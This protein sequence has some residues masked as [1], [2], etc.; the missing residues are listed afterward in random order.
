[1]KKCFNVVTR[2]LLF[3][4]IV[5]SMSHAQ[6]ISSPHLETRGAATQLIVDGRPFVMLSGELDNSSS[7]SLEYMKSVWP[8]LAA[9]GLN[10]V[11]TPLSWELIE[12]T[13][14]NFDFTVVDGL[15]NQARHANERIVFLWFGSWKNGMSSYAPVWVKADTQRFHRVIEYGHEVEILSTFGVATEQADARA[16][17]ALMRHIKQVDGDRHTVLMMQLENE[18]G[19]L[20]DS[21]DH[22]ESANKA[23]ESPVPEQLTSYLK[24]HYNKLYPD[25]R[26]RWDAHGDKAEGTWAEVFGDN[27]RGDEIFM[28]WNYARYI[29]AVA[30]AGKAEYNIPMYVNTWLDDGTDPPGSYPCGDPEPWVI[31]IWRAAGSSIDIY[32]PDLY[33][34]DF[35][36]W[37]QRYHRDGNP[38]Y[39][40]EA[41]GGTTGAA[42]VFYALGQEAGIGFSPYAIDDWSTDNTPLGKSY[43]AIAEVMPLLLED[44]AKGDDRGF[45]LGPD[46]VINGPKADFTM[47]GYTL[48]VTLD[49]GFGDHAKSG[50]GMIMSL[51]KDEFLGVGKGFCVSFTPRPESGL[52]VGIAAVDEGTFKEGKWVPGRRLNGDEDYQGKYWRFDSQGVRIEKVSLYRFQ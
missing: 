24:A 10:T 48:H 17:A 7:S 44:Q 21:R 42:N 39:M 6:E 1:M 43:R 36:E 19:I 30:K 31:D 22:S 49:G 13:E 38:L 18:V 26:A 8:K 40:P 41:E 25:L 11:V 9:L 52:H 3:A 50:F 23:Y 20:G 2:L 16:F 33:E 29:Q 46:A 51:G 45:V 12:P 5:S 4:G 28:A 32:S 14:G 35:E 37:C 47:N 27:E 15:I 34:R